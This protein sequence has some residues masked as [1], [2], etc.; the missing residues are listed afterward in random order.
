MA[1]I[2]LVAVVLL[3][4]AGAA[5]WFLLLRPGVSVASSVDPDVTIECSASLGVDEGVCRG[6]GDAALEAGP[7]STTFELED[8]VRLRLDRGPLGGECRFE[9]F[10][11]RYPDEA[12]WT[13]T[14]ACGVSGSG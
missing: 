11:S 13:E 12:I 3:V 4:V 9:Y 2:G 1:R 5:A 14:A 10:L 6:L 8:V 7:P